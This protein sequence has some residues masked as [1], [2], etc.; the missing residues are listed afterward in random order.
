MVRQ[1]IAPP[2]WLTGPLVGLL[3]V[4]IGVAFGF[5]AGYAI[6]PARDLG[7]RLF[8]AVALGLGRTVS[9]LILLPIT[10][11]FLLRRAPER[12][13][14]RA[15]LARVLGRTPSWLE[16]ARHFHTFAGVTLDRIREL[17]ATGAD[18]PSRS[19]CR[20]SGR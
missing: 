5:N 7:P 8:T 17:A 4:A 18:S 14:S 6:N 3:V 11:Y 20:R 16:V 10:A 1:L 19:R 12:R 2:A 13:A 15:Y 9:R